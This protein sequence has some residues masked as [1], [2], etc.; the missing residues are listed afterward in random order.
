MV[1]TTSFPSGQTEG[2]TI[3]GITLYSIGSIAAGALVVCLTTK[4][5]VKEFELLAPGLVDWY[6]E[7]SPAGETEV[8][9]RNSAFETDIAKTNLTAILQQYGLENV[10][11]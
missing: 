7:L 5:A 1:Q 9:F 4:F 2:K 6:E 10:R 11:S 3:A 8:V